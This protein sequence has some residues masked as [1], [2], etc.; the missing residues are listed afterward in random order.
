MKK[1]THVFMRTFSRYDIGAGRPTHLSAWSIDRQYGFDGRI[2]YEGA[3]FPACSVSKQLGNERIQIVADGK[4]VFVRGSAGYVR[5]AFIAWI[6]QAGNVQLWTDRPVEQS[7]MLGSLKLLG[8]RI[9]DVETA[10]FLAGGDI[11]TV[12]RWSVRAAAEFIGHSEV[13]F[14]CFAGIQILNKIIKN[15]DIKGIRST[16]PA[17]S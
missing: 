6:E 9:L 5:R 3:E 11:D 16:T 7:L 14:Q 10:V 13:R 4:G 2:E 15:E 17:A 12:G 8:L 1:M